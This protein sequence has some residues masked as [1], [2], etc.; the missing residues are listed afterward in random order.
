MTQNI[1]Q[2][3][4]R[5]VAHSSLVCSGAVGLP[6]V[7]WFFLQ[8]MRMHKYYLVFLYVFPATHS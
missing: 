1:N 6:L 3:L 5:L 4:P 2:Q 7:D 8:L